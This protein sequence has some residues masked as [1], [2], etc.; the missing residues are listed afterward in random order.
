MRVLC[1]PFRVVASPT[2]TQGR[3]APASQSNRWADGCNPVGI[4][5]ESA[6]MCMG[7]V[8]VLMRGW[9]VDVEAA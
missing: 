9:R 3:I 8:V 5:Q 1:N 4:G 7:D 6:G 2:I